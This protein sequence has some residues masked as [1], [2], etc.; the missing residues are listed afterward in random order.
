VNSTNVSIGQGNSAAIDTGTTLIGAPTTAVKA[1]WGA[2]SGAVPLSGNMAGFWGFRMCTFSSP[3]LA[4][5]RSKGVKKFS[6]DGLSPY[7]ITSV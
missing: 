2:V 5:P 3:S 7:P 1:I 6:A 4:V